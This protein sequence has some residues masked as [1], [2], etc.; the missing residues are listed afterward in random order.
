MDQERE[1]R[2]DRKIDAE[3]LDVECLDQ[4]D[5][6]CKW[7]ERSIGA[8]ALVEDL[9]LSL[10]AKQAELDLRIR[11][12]PEKHGLEKLTEAG[13]KAAVLNHPE[14]LKA[15]KKFNRA[16][17]EA[18]YL[19]TAVSAMEMKKRMIEQLIVLHGQQYF[20]GPSVP[21]DLGKM[22]QLAQKQSEKR[23]TEKVLQIRR[24]RRK[25]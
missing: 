3:G 6:F 14:F 21:R 10:E 16:R 4:V 8:K 9:K 1:L 20:A 5:L 2:K 18:A 17:D 12:R 24:I 15:R 23:V 22:W 11:K 25:E 7:A 19:D 13:V